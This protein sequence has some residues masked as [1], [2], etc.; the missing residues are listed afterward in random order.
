MNARFH[1]PA[2]AVSR[3]ILVITSRGAGERD[4]AARC[5]AENRIAARGAQV[6]PVK[7]GGAVNREI[8]PIVVAIAV[9]RRHFES[10]IVVQ[11]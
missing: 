6:E 4:V 10:A 7:G 5:Y 2:I 1:T 9:N 8:I 11:E 3:V